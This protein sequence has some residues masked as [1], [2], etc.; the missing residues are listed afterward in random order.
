MTYVS[1]YSLSF[2]S[3]QIVSVITQELCNVHIMLLSEFDKRV[4]K[5]KIDFLINALKFEIAYFSLKKYFTAAT[6]IQQLMLCYFVKY[7]VTF[8]EI[9]HVSCNVTYN[10]NRI[11]CYTCLM[12]SL[13][14]V[15]IYTLIITDF[16]HINTMNITRYT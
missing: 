4:L 3:F 8:I 7:D 5:A 13:W 12:T 15:I 9:V 16:A 10:Y 1:T 6:K 14:N 2:H 11:T